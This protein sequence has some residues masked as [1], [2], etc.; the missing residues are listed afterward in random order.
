MRLPLRAL[1]LRPG[2]MKPVPGQKNVKTSYRI[3][4]VTLPADEPLLPRPRPEPGEPRHD[5]LRTRG[6][7]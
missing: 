4:L 7:A 5:P 6:R 1:R 2:L 3:L